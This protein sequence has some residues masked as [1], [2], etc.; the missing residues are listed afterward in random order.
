[1]ASRIFLGGICSKVIILY[2][3]YGEIYLYVLQ[4]ISANSLWKHQ[5]PT[6]R[7]HCC[8]DVAQQELTI[9][10]WGL[11]SCSLFEMPDETQDP[12]HCT[13]VGSVNRSIPLAP[14]RCVLSRERQSRGFYGPGTT[15]KASVLCRRNDQ[16]P[17]HNLFFMDHNNTSRAA[18]RQ[19]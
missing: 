7:Y 16:G 4:T 19:L 18:S 12:V 1:M 13:Y 3:S 5:Y 8:N 11:M 15:R 2:V 9:N 6:P 14:L 10:R 17:R